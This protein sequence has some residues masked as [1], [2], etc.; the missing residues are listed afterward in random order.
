MTRL[1]PFALIV[2]LAACGLQIPFIGGGGG[3]ASEP[4]VPE[5]A[6]D[7]LPE[8]DAAPSA[9]IA[10]GALGTTLASLGDATVQGLWL[11]TPLVTAPGPGRVTSADGASVE[12]QLIPS[13]GL[14]GAGSRLSLA[15]MQALGLPLTAIAEVSVEAL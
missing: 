3:R 6:A 5:T 12:V 8:A 13:G 2:P 4:T 9:D 11:E 14:E 10:A 7:P 1:L 15:A